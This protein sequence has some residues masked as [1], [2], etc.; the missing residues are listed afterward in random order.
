MIYQLDFIL[1][2]IEET[3][4]LGMFAASVGY[5]SSN[6]IILLLS[7][8]SAAPNPGDLFFS[9]GLGRHMYSCVLD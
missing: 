7:K 8:T 4:G 2:A 9:F 6:S 5:L 1:K 3:Q